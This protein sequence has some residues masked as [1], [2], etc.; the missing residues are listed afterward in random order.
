MQ[1]TSGPAP[2]EH[3]PASPKT[4]Q[5]T[6]RQPYPPAGTSSGSARGAGKRTSRAENHPLR[7]PATVPGPSWQRRSGRKLSP[8]RAR[9][10][11]GS[12]PLP[13]GRRSANRSTTVIIGAAPNDNHG[14][15]AGAPLVY[16]IMCYLAGR[17]SRRCSSLRR[18]ESFRLRAGR[19]S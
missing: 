18:C 3:G 19:E 5:D 1:N 13:R 2:A 16:V 12:D 10:D 17:S 11:A 15:S 7:D 8:V 4:S 14:H 6:H 9:R